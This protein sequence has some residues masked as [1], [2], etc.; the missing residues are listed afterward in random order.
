VRG[1]ACRGEGRGREEGGY[2]S[3]RGE[4]SE[5]SWC[6]GGG[7]RG[8]PPSSSSGPRSEGAPSMTAQGVQGARG[9]AAGEVPWAVGAERVGQQ[10]GGRG[11]GGGAGAVGTW[12]AP[13][14]APGM[15]G[16]GDEVRGWKGGATTCPPWGHGAAVGDREPGAPHPAPPAAAGGAV[17]ASRA[18][19]AGAGGRRGRQALGCKRERG[20]F[21]GWERGPVPYCPRAPGAPG[22]GWLWVSS[23]QCFRAH[24]APLS[25]GTA[26]LLL[27]AAVM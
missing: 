26:A 24:S 2:S 12:G 13:G 4:S 23:L 6:G 11:G 21:Y 5:G 8:V 27:S 18:A 25:S 15:R 17:P 19:R 22:A 16:G 7:A 9:C 1:R 14:V 10:R 20:C 3:G